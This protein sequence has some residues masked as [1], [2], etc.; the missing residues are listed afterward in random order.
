MDI[1]RGDVL[2]EAAMD[3]VACVSDGVDMVSVGGSGVD[4]NQGEGVFAGREFDR[5][6]RGW[7]SSKLL[8]RLLASLVDLFNS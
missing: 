6:W 7:L 1:G 5:L 8:G 3:S 4:E 2:D